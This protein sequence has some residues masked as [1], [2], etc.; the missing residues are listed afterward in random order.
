[1]N[2][3]ERMMKALGGMMSS[4]DFEKDFNEIFA[5]QI[6]EAEKGPKM[7]DKIV[8]EY[9]DGSKDTLDTRNKKCK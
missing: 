4:D 8:I 1:M 6:A 7:P 5:E 2:D 3:A 9:N